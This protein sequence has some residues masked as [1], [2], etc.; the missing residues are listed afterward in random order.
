MEGV[1]TGGNLFSILLIE[2]RWLSKELR[3]PRTM[4]R[5]EKQTRTVDRAN[6]IPTEQL[7][8]V[9]KI[10]KENFS[11]SMKRKKTNKH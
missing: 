10:C 2:G 5:L 1:V 7:T 3:N 6:Y 8:L 4:D 11:L 9:C